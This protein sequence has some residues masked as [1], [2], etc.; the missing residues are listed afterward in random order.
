M[1]KRTGIKHYYPRNDPYCMAHPEI[2]RFQAHPVTPP[3]FP[4][5]PFERVY[6]IKR[7]LSPEEH[8]YELMWSL[9]M[10]EDMGDP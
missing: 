4:A 5:C 9:L 3:L 1:W 2:P 10:D 6:K 7:V 8:E